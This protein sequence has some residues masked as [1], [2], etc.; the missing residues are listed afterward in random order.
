MSPKPQNIILFG[1]PRSGSTWLS[2]IICH[3][4]PLKQVHEPDNEL[5]SVWGLHHKKG[6][7]RF[8][9][10]EA[11]A[12]QPNY[13]QLFKGALEASVPDQKD[14]KNKLLR[15][16]YRLQTNQLQQSLQQ[17]G[18]ALN[19][20][21]PGFKLLTS[22]LEGSQAKQPRLLK[23][24]HALLAFPYL[25][26]QLNFQAIVLERHPLNSFSSYVKMKM[27]DG[28]R[29]LFQNKALLAALDIKPF[30]KPSA[31]YSYAFLA[32]YQAGI[33]QKQIDRLKSKYPSVHFLRY[34]T[35]IQ[36]PFQSMPKLLNE[37][38]LSYTVKT[39]QFMEDRFTDGDGYTTKRSLKGQVEIWKSRL[40][41]AEK[42]EF[43]EGYLTSYDSVNFE[44]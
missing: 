13:L 7:A 35:L 41:A 22:W 18:T 38:G 33:F 29:N 1:T 27:P 14:F 37:L 23:S 44:L 25:Y 36:D 17:K 12:H 3:E 15:K 21:L 8:P 34:E 4:N 11:N 43:V 9:F 26:E 30:E 40:T 10:L 19:R 24:V 16:L 5:N 20:D 32:G 39:K 31:Q 28:N 42:D 2:E 6:L